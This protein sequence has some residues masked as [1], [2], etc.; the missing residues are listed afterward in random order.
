[1]GPRCR[2]DVSRE[3]EHPVAD[4]VALDLVGASGD[5]GRERADHLEADVGTV[6][7]VRL[8]RLAGDAGDL[9]RH[10][11]ELPGDL[12]TRRAC[13]ASRPG[14]ARCR[15][16]SSARTR[17]ATS[18]LVVSIAYSRI[19]RSRTTGSSIAPLARATAT[20]SSKRRLA[21]R[22]GAHRADRQPLVHQHRRGLAPAVVELADQPIGRDPHVAEEHLVE[23]TATVDLMDRS[24]LDAGRLHV[25]DEH[26]DARRAWAAR[27]RCGRSAS[28]SR[29]RG[30]AS[31][32]PSAR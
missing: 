6:R 15:P 23:M 29:T 4:D 9:H 5:P 14:R 11:P 19:S 2:R 1:M 30:R 16:G 17:I 22:A 32:T 3:A 8:P 26:R 13:R 25:D 27:G 31:S 21:D 10:R 28:R 20:R 18:A 24:D 12:R 7:I